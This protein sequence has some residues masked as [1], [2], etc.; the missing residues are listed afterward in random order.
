MYTAKNTGR[1]RVWA[2]PYNLEIGYNNEQLEWKTEWETGLPAIDDEHKALLDLTNQFIEISL[3]PERSEE[4][5]AFMQTIYHGLSGH[6]VHEEKILM[7]VQ[8]PETEK[9]VQIHSSILRKLAGLVERIQSGEVRPVAFYI[10]IINE[11]VVGH[12]LN[13]DVKY[14]PFIRRLL[15]KG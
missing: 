13:T 12:M 4:I 10:F 2:V 3:S 7:D 1:N 6:F 11:I 15:A 5:P 9:H 8:Y 14:F